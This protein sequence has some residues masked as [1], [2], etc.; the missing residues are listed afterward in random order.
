MSAQASVSELI[1]DAAR[2]DKQ[3]FD[4]F[5]KKMVMLRAERSSTVL[6]QEESDLLQKINRGFPDD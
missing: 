2:L 1:D 6:P 4:K 5:F 3:E